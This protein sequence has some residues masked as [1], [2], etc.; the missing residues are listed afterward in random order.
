M[1]ETVNVSFDPAYLH[2]LPAGTVLRGRYQIQRLLG[3]GGFGITYLGWDHQLGIPVAIKEFFPQ[4]IVN[5][6][7]GW[8]F[9]VCCNTNTLIPAYRGSMERFLREAE[10][11]GR[12]REVSAI[13][14]IRDLFEAN[15]TAYIVMEYIDGPNLKQYIDQ[16]GGRLSVEETLAVLEPVIRALIT[17]HREGMVHRDISP[18]NIMLHPTQGAKLL[19]FGAVR[20]VENP[21]VDKALSHSTE[22]ILKHGFAPIEQYHSRGALGPWTD[23]YALCATVYYCLTGAVPDPV[24]TRMSEDTEPEWGVI[25][26]LSARR[27]A[28]LEKGMSIKAKDRF[29]DL[30]ELYVQLYSAPECGTGEKKPVRNWVKKTVIGIAAAVL[31]IALGIAAWS[32]IRM[33]GDGGSPGGSGGGKPEGG[34]TTPTSSAPSTPAVP[35]VPETEHQPPATKPTE[36][37]PS[38]DWVD[39]VLV[40]DPLNILLNV[41][42]TDEEKI[43]KSR[44]VVGSVTFLDDLSQCPSN[45]VALGA[46]GSDCVVGWTVHNGSY[47]DIYIAAEGGINGYNSCRQLFFGCENMSYVDFGGAFHT[48]GCDDMYRMFSGCYSLKAIDLSSFDTSDVLTMQEMFRECGSITEL[49]LSGFDTSKVTNMNAMFSTCSEMRYIDLSGF[50]TS[51]L[52]NMGYMFS[53]NRNLRNVNVSSFDTSKVTNMAGVF[54]WCGLLEDV[55]LSSWSTDSVKDYSMFMNDGKTVNGRP[56]KEFFQK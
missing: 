33:L 52:T 13:V 11:L 8:S 26:G 37:A 29:A 4:S 15:N 14:E 54:A 43:R 39:N 53:A 18:D 35:T 51:S 49:D 38:M 28:A 42:S 2:T 1:D 44:E 6:N 24:A 17:V 47:V 9:D 5:R 16:K 27:R 30:E 19:D 40:R 10:A 25:P 12:F 55:D 22:A 20:S 23:E 31:A 50:D 36:I 46:D 32:A 56:W 21:H 34:E 48:D 3:Q 45:A 41:T 7:C